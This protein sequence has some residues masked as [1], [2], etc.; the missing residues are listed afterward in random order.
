MNK[1]ARPMVASTLR[2]TII[3]ILLALVAMA[4]QGQVKYVTVP[5]SIVD[6]YW[7]N[8]KT[9]DWKIGFTDSCAIYD[10]QIWN[11]SNVKDKRGKLLLT[12]THGS[13]TIDV[14]I[15]KQKEGKCQM[16][17]GSNKKQTYGKITARTLPLY[18]QADQ[19]PFADNGFQEG[20]S[21]VLTGWLKDYPALQGKKKL[22]VYSGGFIT[23]MQSTIEGELDVGGRF[24]VKVPLENTQMVYLWVDDDPWMVDALLQPG[25]TCFALYDGKNSKYLFMGNNSRVQNE[26]ATARFEME[27]NQVP[28][29]EN[30]SD[31]QMQTFI[32]QCLTV[33]HKNEAKVDSI[34][35]T[36]MTLSRKFE[37]FFRMMDV[38][39]MARDMMQ[40]SSRSHYKLP[41]AVTDSTLAELRRNIRKPYSISEDFEEFIYRYAF[42]CI[43]NSSKTLHYSHLDE[44]YILK[45]GKEGWLTLSND[46]RNVLEEVK[47]LRER[48]SGLTEDESKAEYAH[49][50]DLMKSWNSIMQS[51]EVNVAITDKML[52]ESI[53]NEFE[54]MDSAFTDP[55]LRECTKASRIYGEMDRTEQ[56]LK[57]FYLDAVNKIQLP[58]ARNAILTKNDELTALQNK[59]MTFVG[60]RPSSDVANMTDGEKILRKLIEP[61]KGK[62]ILLDIWGTWCGPCKAALAHSQEEYERLKDY[63]LVYLYLANNSPDESWKNV[64]KMYNVTGDNVVHYNL[65]RDQQSAI[66]QYLNVLAFPTYKLIDREG[67]ILDADIDPRNLDKLV[68]LLERLKNKQEQ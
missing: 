26:L 38:T 41:Q 53:I 58:A 22:K 23:G 60:L 39:R 8:E 6:T 57:K 34:M 19:T 18:P 44:D 2:R 29:D 36:N 32:N 49:N 7:R 4:G 20:D 33:Y 16:T 1:N 40:I 28:D 48:C 30:L 14:T 11:Y 10:C 62:Y 54:V 25:D 56:P 65:P 31:E 13:E 66:E 17:I 61:Y 35:A 9:G 46:D 50:S 68:H 45:L 15:G 43:M 12:L 24:A 47:R 3:T 51:K 67:T 37:D 63:D 55:V 64:I 21:A 42:H 27:F 5:E 52:S 59:P